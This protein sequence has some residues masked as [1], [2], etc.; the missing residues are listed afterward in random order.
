VRDAI[1]PGR[2]GHAHDEVALFVS[3]ERC[4]LGPDLIQHRHQVVHHDLGEILPPS[5]AI[6][7]IDLDQLGSAFIPRAPD[8]RILR[9]RTDNL[10]AIWPNLRSA[11]IRHVVISGAIST[12]EELRLIREA[13]DPSDLSVVRLVTTPALLEARLRR[14]DHG[15]R[16]EDHLA[17]VPRIDRSL[18]ESALEDI[19]VMNDARSPREV[20]MAIL[21][22]IGWD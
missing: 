16:L 14:R 12:R 4:S 2:R 7:C 3:E 13:V 19:R 1:R 5:R 9:L 10:A 15:R 17:I 11:G 21:R 20:A 8:D 6:I 18:D 22:A